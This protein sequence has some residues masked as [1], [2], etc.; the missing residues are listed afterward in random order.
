M[1]YLARGIQGNNFFGQEVKGYLWYSCLTGYRNLPI[2]L[3]IYHCLNSSW[4]VNYMFFTPFFSNSYARP[5]CL[6]SHSFILTRI[7]HDYAKLYVLECSCYAGP[8]T[9][10]YS[11]KDKSGAHCKLL[12]LGSSPGSWR[13][14]A[15]SHIS[16]HSGQELY[17]DLISACIPNRDTWLWN[18]NETCWKNKGFKGITEWSY[19]S[20]NWSKK[21]AQSLPQ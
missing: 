6:S 9:S 11:C 19:I 21:T 14:M 13:E 10:F 4:L 15:H 8:D 2:L 1:L 18:T 16:Q 5:V 7:M 20:Y 3:I 17:G 12:C